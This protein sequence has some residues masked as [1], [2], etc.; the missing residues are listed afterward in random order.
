MGGA[1]RHSYNGYSTSLLNSGVSLAIPPN[2]I[3]ST[4][5]SSI[6]YSQAIYIQ[7][8]KLANPSAHYGL[9]Q[10]MFLTA[11]SI[12]YIRCL[13][14]WADVTTKEQLWLC[15]EWVTVMPA[16]GV[17]F[18]I[19]EDRVSWAFLVDVQLKPRPKFDYIA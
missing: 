14:S 11:G 15:S 4:A 8:S 9:A 5:G 19:R 1:E 18:Y 2:S 3:D 16:G 6:L 12:M 13:E 17:R 10:W 7:Q